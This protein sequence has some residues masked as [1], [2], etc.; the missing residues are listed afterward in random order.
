[1]PKGEDE[2]IAVRDDEFFR[3]VALPATRALL[4]RPTLNPSMIRDPRELVANVTLI[5]PL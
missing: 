3:F 2:E 4:E 5:R 1:M